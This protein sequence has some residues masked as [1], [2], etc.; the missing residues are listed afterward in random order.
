[1]PIEL[2]NVHG[3]D[4]ESKHVIAMNRMQMDFS[5]C[6]LLLQ[7]WISVPWKY[8]GLYSKYRVHKGIS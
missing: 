6:I 1:M 8:A 7:P 4:T 3:Q 2:F 5:T